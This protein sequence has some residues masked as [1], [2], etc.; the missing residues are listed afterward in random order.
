[1]KLTYDDVLIVPQFSEIN[2]RADVNIS[3]FGLDVPV[4]SANMDTVT[5]HLMAQAMVKNGGV[6]ALHRFSQIAKNIAMYYDSP[7]ETFCSVGVGDN[8]KNRARALAHAGCYRFILDVAH[9]AQQQVVDQAKW[10]LDS[11]DVELIV[12]NFASPRSMEEFLKRTK[13]Y[14]ITA[15]KVGIGPGAV[16]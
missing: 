10:L 1:M 5:D 8:E 14:N 12:G 4:I 3:S 13:G 6:G 16:S 9:G 7:E 15:F 11:Y 2:S